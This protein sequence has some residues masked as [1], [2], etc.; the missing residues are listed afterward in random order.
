MIGGKGLNQAALVKTLAEKSPDAIDYL[1]SLGASL[2]S[3]ASFGGASV[4]RIHRP[5][6]AE[7]KTTAVGA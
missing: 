2:H 1:D 3:V 7:G 6:N 5:V 4:K